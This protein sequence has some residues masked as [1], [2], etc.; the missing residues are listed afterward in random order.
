MPEPGAAELTPRPQ[1]GRTFS[2]GR[3][4]RLGDVDPTGRCRLDAVVRYLQD[5]ARDDSADADLTDPMHWVVRRVLLEVKRA[6][7]FQ[8]DLEMATWCSGHGARWA[9]RRTEI[10]G[11]HG[12]HVEA[13]TVWIF[14]DAVTGAPR[15][16]RDDFFEIYGATAADRRISARLSLPT[17]P[18]ADAE[19]VAWPVRYGDLDVLGHV[20]NAAQWV[21]IEE[22]R[23]RVDAPTEGIRAE[24]EHGPGI[25]PGEATL[26]WRGDA[27]G[28]DTWLLT[29]TGTGSVGR[30]RLL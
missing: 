19:S 28:L 1:E 12:A 22:A 10:R 7:V 26:C 16:L 30:V 25:G 6:P 15:P 2:T 3:R 11:S 21:P 5:V 29:P 17:R 9:E 18:A 4:V 13:V 23:Y 20:N 24:I 8:E 27:T 14:V